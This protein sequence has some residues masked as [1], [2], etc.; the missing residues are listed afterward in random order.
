VNRFFNTTNIKQALFISLFF[1]ITGT[2]IGLVGLCSHFGFNNWFFNLI[3]KIFGLFWFIPALGIPFLFVLLIFGLL[4]FL[5]NFWS[6]TQD[7]NTNLTLSSVVVLLALI[8]L[9][10]QFMAVGTQF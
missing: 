6:K 10:I 9:V 7:C 4:T 8:T 2:C 3:K 1:L 5:F